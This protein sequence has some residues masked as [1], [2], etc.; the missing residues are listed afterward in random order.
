MK[1]KIEKIKILI[2]EFIYYMNEFHTFIYY[3]Q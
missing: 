3:I 2:Y 1:N